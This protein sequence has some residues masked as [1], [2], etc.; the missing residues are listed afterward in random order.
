MQDTLEQED[1]VREETKMSALS[2][3]KVQKYS[4]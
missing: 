1:K 4:V 2:R 3:D